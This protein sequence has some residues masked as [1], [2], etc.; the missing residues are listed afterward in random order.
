MFL[1]LLYW[2]SKKKKKKKKEST[3]IIEYL[4][5]IYWTNVDDWIRAA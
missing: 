2:V 4:I 3:T 5:N 1:M